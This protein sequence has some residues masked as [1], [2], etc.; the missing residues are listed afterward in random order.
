MVCILQNRHS[1]VTN[2][3]YIA[4][5]RHCSA[6]LPENATLLHMRKKTGNLSRRQ[7]HRKKGTEQASPKK[8]FSL[9]RLCTAWPCMEPGRRSSLN[10][11]QAAHGFEHGARAACRSKRLGAMLYTW[12]R[13]QRKAATAAR[14]RTSVRGG[15]CGDVGR[16]RDPRSTRALK[17]PRGLRGP[18]L[19]SCHRD[20]EAVVDVRQSK[21]VCH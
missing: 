11:A 1:S 7:V 12:Q 21:W 15:V 17:S 16:A 18:A 10:D 6:G 3:V 5:H 8:S 19:R 4:D 9:Y 2:P 14:S 20:R 13:H